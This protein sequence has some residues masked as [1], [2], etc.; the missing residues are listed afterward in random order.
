VRLMPTRHDLS[1][2]GISKRNTRYEPFSNIM[3]GMNTRQFPSLMAVVALLLTGS[4]AAL[5]VD[6][7]QAQLTQAEKIYGF[8]LFWKEVSYNFAHWETAGDLDWDQAYQDFLPAIMASENDF[9]YYRTMQRFCALLR[10]GHTNVYMPEGLLEANVGRVPLRMREL[11]HRAIVTNMDVSLAEEIPRGSE[12]LEVDGQPVAEMVEN[13]IIPMISTS[14]PHIYWDM[15]VASQKSAGVGILFGERGSTARLE[16][17]RPDGEV[18]LVDAPRDQYEREV[19]WAEEVAKTPLI[20]SRM[21]EG[22]IAYVALNSFSDEEIVEA[23][24]ETLPWLAGAQGI[25]LDLRRNSGG[26]SLNASAIVGH[27]ADEPFRGAS[28]RTPV[29]YGVYRAWGRFADSVSELEE[30]RGYYEGHVYH[31]EEADEHEPA[32]GIRLAA[33]T[34]VLI[35]RQTASSAE[36]FLIMADELDQFT[37]LG[38]PTFGSTGQPLMM[39]LPGGGSARISTKRDFYPDGR[40]FIGHGVRPDI[41]VKPTVEA[42]LNQRDEAL[43]RAVVELQSKAAE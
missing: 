14:A 11:E 42:F 3:G 23:F 9:E 18:V 22:G 15:A 4:A 5:A 32:K 34:I 2:Q 41:A 30:Y 43:E 10:D 1:A 12:V 16:I 26:S 33:P 25:I 7:P 28:W 21:L 17:R 8:S 31:R 19:E 37:Y 20:E 36:D 24:R 27:F 6:Q 39:D 40:E 35:G 13:E 29:N 38:E